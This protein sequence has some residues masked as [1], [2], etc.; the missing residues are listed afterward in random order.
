MAFPAPFPIRLGGGPATPITLPDIRKRQEA[1]TLLDVGAD[2]STFPDLDVS[3]AL[4]QGRRVLLEA[5]ARR[6]ITP[7]GALWKHPSYGCDLRRYLNKPMTSQLL[8]RIKQESE[9]EAEQE[10]R[11]L[12]CQNRV[13]FDDPSRTLLI[14]VGLTDADGPFTFTAGID[15]LGLSLLQSQ[16]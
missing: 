6:Y 15:A 13:A 2:I 3:F 4:M 9:G 8:A 5:V 1:G 14:R 16:E 11:V 10:E 7:K 12:A